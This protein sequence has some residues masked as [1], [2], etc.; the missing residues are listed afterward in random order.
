MLL[1]QLLDLFKQR[2][3]EEAMLLR[4]EAQVSFEQLSKDIEEFPQRVLVGSDWVVSSWGLV[5]RDCWYKATHGVHQAQPE[6]PALFAEVL[7]NMF[8]KFVSRVQE[9]G[10]RECLHLPGTWTLR[11]A[12]PEPEYQRGSLGELSH[13]QAAADLSPLVWPSS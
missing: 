13:R 3:V 12:W 10:F 8:P 7:A 9:L 6:G 5:R 4:C 11:V 2:C 1:D